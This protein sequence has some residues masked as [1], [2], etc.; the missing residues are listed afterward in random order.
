MYLF[1]CVNLIFYNLVLPDHVLEEAVPGNIRKGEHFVA[2]IKRLVEYLKTRLRY[3]LK[4]DVNIKNFWSLT[5]FKGK[6]SV[7]KFAL[8]YQK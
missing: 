2:F 7:Y 1:L 5:F 6:I 3:G 4:Y 8:L